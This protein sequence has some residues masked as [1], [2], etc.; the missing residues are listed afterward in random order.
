MGFYRQRVQIRYSFASKSY[1]LAENQQESSFPS[2]N[3]KKSS[4]WE[5]EAHW[6]IEVGT[7]EILSLSTSKPYWVTRVKYKWNCEETGFPNVV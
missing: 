2:K 4:F 5:K 7:V 1:E 6:M 3:Q